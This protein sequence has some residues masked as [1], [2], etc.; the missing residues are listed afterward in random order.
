MTLC[1][2]Y[3]I[4]MKEVIIYTD[5]A[6]SGNPGMGGW[7][8]VLI[9][10]N[11]QKQISG[12]EKSTTNNRME[13]SAIINALKQLKEKCVVTVHTDSA[14]ISNA[15]LNN[16]V[17]N[18]QNNGWRTADKKQIQ[19]QDLWKEL[20]DLCNVHDVKFVKVKGHSDDELN[21]L[22]DKLATGE[23]AKHKSE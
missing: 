20:I 11:T 15:F 23:I 1:L 7:G 6:C 12:F 17:E 9:Y 4:F 10:K 21:N 22:C 13:L 19:N 3:N 18:W 16:W 2:C 5:G 8:A 14:Y